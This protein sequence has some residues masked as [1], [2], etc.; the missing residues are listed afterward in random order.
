M[1]PVEDETEEEHASDAATERF[2]ITYNS[3]ATRLLTWPVRK[4]LVWFRAFIGFLRWYSMPLFVV[5]LVLLGLW[6]LFS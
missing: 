6:Y 5:L 2:Q 1:I 3:T 4:T